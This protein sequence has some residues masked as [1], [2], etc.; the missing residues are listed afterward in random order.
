MNQWKIF[1]SHSLDSKID[2]DKSATARVLRGCG[3]PRQHGQAALAINVSQPSISK[4]IA[5]LEA[6]WGEQLFVR[7]HAVG[8]D[9]T[10]AGLARS[11]E[12]LSLL[13]AAQRLQEPRKQAVS[14]TL[15]LGFLSTLGA[16]WIPQ[17]LT[18][19]QSATRPSTSSLIEGDI[20][21]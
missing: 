4:A 2:S 11:R 8:L 9:L 17:L 16:L 18:Q 10:A 7:K 3:T 5:D 21:S 1:I 14:G 6:Q 20:A 12:A 19:M 13:E 15:R